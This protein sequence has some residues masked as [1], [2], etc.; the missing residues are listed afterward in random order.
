MAG[1]EI[2]FNASG[3]ARTPLASNPS[4]PAASIIPSTLVSHNCSRWPSQAYMLSVPLPTRACLL[5]IGF[6]WF[7]VRILTL[8]LPFYPPIAKLAANN[9]FS[10]RF[11]LVLKGA[12]LLMQKNEYL[13]QA[14]ANCTCFGAIFSKT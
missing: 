12:S 2:I 6:V 13:F 11:A 1:S 8:W 7:L 14:T 5:H 3:S 9:R 4:L 10:R